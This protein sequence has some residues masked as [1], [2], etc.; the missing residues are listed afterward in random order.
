MIITIEL[1]FK[2]SHSVSVIIFIS[3]L[4]MVLIT[5]EGA[6]ITY[7]CSFTLSAGEHG[8]GVLR[9]HKGISRPLVCTFLSG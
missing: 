4:P 9:E 6:F 8:A 5:H 7:C 2:A 1:Q 3:P